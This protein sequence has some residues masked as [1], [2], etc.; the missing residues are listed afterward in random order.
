[1]PYKALADANIADPW[2][3]Y[4]AQDHF[5]WT[6]Y[7]N[8]V[9]LLAAYGMSLTTG[10]ILEHQFGMKRL[11]AAIIGTLTATFFGITKEVMFDRYTSRTDI[12]TWTVGGFAGGLTMTLLR[13]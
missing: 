4:E 11:P 7:D 12:K 2:D 10:L 5:A 8:D 6:N 1:M 9:H 13:F 3:S